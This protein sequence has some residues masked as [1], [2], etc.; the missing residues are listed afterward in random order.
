MW[1]LWWFYIRGV[2]SVVDEAVV[3]MVDVVRVCVV[4][5]VFVVME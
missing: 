4:V 3:F 2:S 1:S 5:L